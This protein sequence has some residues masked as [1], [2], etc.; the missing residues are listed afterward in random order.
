MK[1]IL[2]LALLATSIPFFTPSVTSENGPANPVPDITLKTID[3]QEIRL[4]SLKGKVV[5][6]D[7]WASWCGPCCRDMAM[8]LKP[9]YEKYKDQGFEIYSVSLDQ[10]RQQWVQG[11]EKQQVSWIN[12]SDLKG[13]QS[14]VARTYG[15]NKIPSTFLLDREGNLIAV[16][17]RG[18]ALLKTLEKM[19]GNS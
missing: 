15:I 16:D 17:I 7:F 9:A 6:I 1:S 2:M 13:W 3:N 10:N 14:P 18:E 8:Y 4:S 5:L 12:V 11:S 19:F